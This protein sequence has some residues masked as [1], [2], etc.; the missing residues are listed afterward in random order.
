MSAVN[1][2]KKHRGDIKRVF[3]MSEPVF[4]EIAGACRDV[5]L[6]H[7][8]EYNTIFDEKT[9]HTLIQRADKFIECILSVVGICPDQLEV[10]LHILADKGNIAF[11][12][13]AERIAQS[14]KLSII[15]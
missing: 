2:L 11:I 14:C 8:I 13:L 12:R 9:G 5:K 10:F 7:S 15:F 3:S 6:I 4:H 1:A